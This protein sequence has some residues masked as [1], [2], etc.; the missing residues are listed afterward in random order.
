MTSRSKIL[1]IASFSGSNSQRTW[2]GSV[3]IA[4]NSLSSMA[5]FTI[6][7]V[8]VDCC[9][10]PCLFIFL[11][12][13]S[14]LAWSA[15]CVKT[16]TAPDRH[17]SQMRPLLVWQP[18]AMPVF[19]VRVVV[20]YVLRARPK[21]LETVLLRCAFSVLVQS[22]LLHQVLWFHSLAASHCFYCYLWWA[23]CSLC[24]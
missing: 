22:Q 15:A 14:S 3:T 20:E 13:C 19:E 10:S 16:P 7:T 6:S 21:P 24:S 11:M 23:I 5:Q 2:C 18:V 17:T 4:L 1:G 8:G 9:R 12:S